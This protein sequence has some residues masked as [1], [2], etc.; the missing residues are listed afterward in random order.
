M[1]RP[2]GDR[3]FQLDFD[4]LDHVLR[5]HATAAEG[6]RSGDP[7]SSRPR[8]PSPT[9]MPTSWGPSPSLASRSASMS[10]PTRFGCDPVQR[11]SCPRLLRSRLRRAA[12]AGP[13]AGESGVACVSDV[14][15]RQV[16]PGSFLL[17]KFRLA[18]TRFSGRR[19]PLHPGGVPN[20]PDAV[21]QEAY[22]HEV[23]SAGFWPGSAGVEYPAFY[24]YAYPEPPGFSSA[25]I[26][27]KEAFYSEGLREYILPY[28]AVRLAPDPDRLLH[29]FFDEHLRS[30]RRLRVSGIAPRLNAASECLGARAGFSRAA[31]DAG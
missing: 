3:T 8:A 5:S 15:H 4:F 31:G 13:A 18:V 11:G 7:R 28:D 17:G 24:S 25:P 21:A 22:S 12:L 26:R 10:Y 23:S 1:L 6:G 9:S 16:Q 2:F 19:A 29:G 30:G 20:L 27:P 14:V